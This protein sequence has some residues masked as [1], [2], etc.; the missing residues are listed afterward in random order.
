M[1][2]TS[3]IPRVFFSGAAMAALSSATTA[4]RFSGPRMLSTILN[5]LAVGLSAQLAS[6]KVPRFVENNTLPLP[7]HLALP[8]NHLRLIHNSNMAIK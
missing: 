5:L 6:R 4:P 1:S 8:A 2:L 3:C 7:A